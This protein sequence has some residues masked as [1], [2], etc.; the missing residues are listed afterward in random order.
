[1]SWCSWLSRQSNTLKVSSS[2]LGDAIFAIFIFIII[3]WIH[4]GPLRESLRAFE[5]GKP[6]NRALEHA[7]IHFR[8]LRE[9]LRALELIGPRTVPSNTH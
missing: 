8:P 6:G 5:L 2:S 1:M 9:S 3:I 7:L 4:F